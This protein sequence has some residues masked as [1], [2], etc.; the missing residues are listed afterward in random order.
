MDRRDT[1]V[2]FVGRRDSMSL[3]D[4]G[5]AARPLRRFRR[6]ERSPEEKTMHIQ[7]NTDSSIDGTDGL[8]DHIRPQLEKAL[9]R[10][11]AHITRVE[12]HLTDSNAEKGGEDDVRAVV[13]VRREGKQPLAVTNHGPNP[14]L[15]AIGAAEK[16]ARALAS[17]QGKAR[18]A[19]RSQ[20]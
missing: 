5:T 14:I 19:A 11:A 18:D 4:P 17:D 7:F 16:A 9:E 8:F 3:I 12:I 13:E 15:A 1:D 2:P 6:P 10:F 20:V